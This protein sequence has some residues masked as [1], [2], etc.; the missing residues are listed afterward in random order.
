MGLYMG[1]LMRGAYTSTFWF[2]TDS[3]HTFLQGKATQKLTP[4]HFNT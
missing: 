1:G 4:L 3:L 2:K